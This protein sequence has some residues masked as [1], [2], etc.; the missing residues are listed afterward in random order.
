MAEK[1]ALLPIVALASA[2]QTLRPA[3]SDAESLDTAR[4]IR[5]GS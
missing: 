1:A 2:D 4:A 3:P 5:P